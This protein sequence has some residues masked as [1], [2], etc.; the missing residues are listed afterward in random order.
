MGNRQNWRLQSKKKIPEREWLD[1]DGYFLQMERKDR[2]RLE[3]EKEKEVQKLKEQYRGKGG[4]VSVGKTEDSQDNIEGRP[5]GTW[6]KGD[7]RTIQEHRRDDQVKFD[8]RNEERGNGGIQKD[9]T[10]KATSIEAQSQTQ[11]GKLGIVDRANET[12]QAGGHNNETTDIPKEEK[13]VAQRIK[14]DISNKPLAKKYIPIEHPDGE[15]WPENS[16]SEDFDF[17]MNK[18]LENFDMMESDTNS[19]DWAESTQHFVKPLK[20]FQRGEADQIE[21]GQFRNRKSGQRVNM[22]GEQEQL[23]LGSGELSTS[24]L[25]KNKSSLFDDDEDDDEDIDIKGSGHG[26]NPKMYLEQPESA[27]LESTESKPLNDAEPNPTPTQETPQE[28]SRIEKSRPMDD[29]NESVYGI[30]T[31]INA[32]LEYCH[33]LIQDLKNNYME[34]LIQKFASIRLSKEIGSIFGMQT[35][36]SKLAVQYDA[37][38]KRLT[39]VTD[40]S[41]ANQACPSLANPAIPPDKASRLAT[42]LSKEKDCW[43]RK[44][45]ADLVLSEK[46]Y[47][48]LEQQILASYQNMN[49][50]ATLFSMQKIYH[51]CVFDAFNETLTDFV[52]QRVKFFS[53]NEGDR[54]IWQMTVFSP[55]DVEYVLYRTENLIEQ[56]ARNQCGLI[57]HKEDSLLQ[58]LVKNLDQMR[59]IIYNIFYI[60][61]SIVY[62]T[63]YG[64]K[65][66]SF[67]CSKVFRFR[68]YMRSYFGY[69]LTYTQTLNI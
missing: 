31:N 51:R 16:S 54:R 45:K 57:P 35:N 49:I 11:L 12:S 9:K 1:Y 52:A 60:F 42:R 30:R 13:E 26:L 5:I 40:S 50:N 25:F 10:C 14:T 56:V 33:L 7:M 62:Y 32:V 6:N 2:E 28:P 44:S 29:P 27:K 53:P 39:K 17:E 46:I 63:I 20:N 65:W 41:K 22:R 55:Y 61:Y 34:F 47:L 67:A 48:L 3:T 43:A 58:T 37:N 24:D 66:R 38:G 23:A 4:M 15:L 21:L 8:C 36:P 19:M 18:D 68:Y 59:Y 64:L 69:A